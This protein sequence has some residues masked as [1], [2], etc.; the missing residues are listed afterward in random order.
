MTSFSTSERSVN[1]K[2]Y[3]SS[4]FLLEAAGKKIIIDCGLYQGKAKEE[5]ENFTEF[6]YDVNEIDY[7]ELV[8][9][10]AEKEIELNEHITEELDRLSLMT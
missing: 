8:N 7:I 2:P 4:N 10:S 3:F 6:P 9:D 5:S 1:G